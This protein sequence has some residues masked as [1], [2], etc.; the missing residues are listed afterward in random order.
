M[1]LWDPE[2]YGAGGD[3]EAE[4]RWKTERHLGAGSVVRVFDLGELPI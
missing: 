1:P 3:S 4:V 2:L